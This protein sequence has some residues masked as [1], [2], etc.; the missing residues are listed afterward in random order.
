LKIAM[1]RRHSR[2]CLAAAAS[3]ALATPVTLLLSKR[4]T[5]IAQIVSFEPPRPRTMATLSDPLF[6]RT[7][8]H[9]LEIVQR[10]VGK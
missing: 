2:S 5:R 4:P 10:V 7:Q 9:P 8:P 3:R 6:I 1:S